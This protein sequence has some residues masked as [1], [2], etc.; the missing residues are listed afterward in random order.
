MNI[1]LHLISFF[2][3]AIVAMSNSLIG[4][5]DFKHQ[6]IDI[7]RKHIRN[8]FFEGDTMFFGSGGLSGLY[9]IANPFGGDSLN[10]DYAYDA[11]C[12][13][14]KFTSKDSFSYKFSYESKDYF[15]RDFGVNDYITLQICNPQKSIIKEIQTK[16][17]GPGFMDSEFGFIEFGKYKL[18][19]IPGETQVLDTNYNLFPI[20]GYSI[21]GAKIVNGV[22]RAKLNSGVIVDI[23]TDLN[24]IKRYTLRRILNK[25]NPYT[26]LLIGRFSDEFSDSLYIYDIENLSLITKKRSADFYTDKIFLIDTLLYFFYRDNFSNDESVRIHD[27]N[28]NLVRHYVL[29]MGYYNYLRE[30]LYKDNHFIIKASNSFFTNFF[31]VNKLNLDKLK[32]PKLKISD[33][34]IN[35]VNTSK[36]IYGVCNTWDVDLTISMT[37]KN[38]GTIPIND[39][40]LLPNYINGYTQLDYSTTK[41]QYYNVKLPKLLMPGE[42][43]LVQNIFKDYYNDQLY[44]Q[45]SIFAFCFNIPVVNG[46][47]ND[48]RAESHCSQ[49]S[50]SINAELQQNSITLSPNPVTDI[51]HVNLNNSNNISNIRIFNSLGV[52]FKLPFETI[53]NTVQIKTDQ[54]V[55]DFYILQY[56]SVNGMKSTSFIKL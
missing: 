53:N 41:Q 7:P 39:F 20:Q 14:A 51:L 23:D 50:T 33:V 43:I 5:L 19:F 3:I 34:R 28:L 26:K 31:I 40:Y 49:I 13:L 10:F 45:N 55:S 44:V 15:C 9:Y 12:V 16:L 35:S 22:L 37:V 2:V 6:V 29:N 1:R 18:F 38:T 27:L 36:F 8:I 21:V 25:V 48:E 4:Q 47:V 11:G 17:Y 52:E 30:V 54:L 56:T 42:S 24:I 46:M 32:I